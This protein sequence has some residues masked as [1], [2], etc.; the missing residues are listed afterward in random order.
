METKT[1]TP[2]WG[3]WAVPATLIGTAILIILIGGVSVSIYQQCSTTDQPNALTDY[4]ISTFAIGFGLGILLFLLANWT[5][6]RHAYISVAVLFLLLIILAS[7]NIYYLN[8]NQISN[9]LATNSALIGIA[10]GM[11]LVIFPV[12][13][14]S[15]RTPNLGALVIFTVIIAILAILFASVGLNIYSSQC[16]QPAGTGGSATFLGFSI[17]LAIIAMIV[18]I[19]GYIYRGGHI[20]RLKQAYAT[21]KQK[22][23]AEGLKQI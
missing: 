18:A 12:Y 14:Y 23:T 13:Y 5:F 4:E 22:K 7:I 20:T 21:Y 2:G 19:V 6:G 15:G 17:A 10:L 11:L 3:R 9:S 16:H 1:I 8:N